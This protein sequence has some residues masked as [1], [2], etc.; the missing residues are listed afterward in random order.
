MK[1]ISLAL[2][3]LAGLLATCQASYNPQLQQ[4]LDPKLTLNSAKERPNIVFILTDDQ[5]LQ[6]DSLSYMPLTTKHLKK[7][8]T[9]YKNHFVP[10]AICCPARVSLWT[11]RFAHNTNVTDVSPPYGGYPKFVE[12]G[13]N[14]NFL[15]VW[16][17][18]AGYQTYYVGKLFNAHTVDNYNAPYVA[19]FNGSD[20]LLDPYTYS[21]L[22]ATYQRNHDPPV[23]Y[24]GRHTVDVTTEKA[25]GFLD[26][27]IATQQ[28]FFLGIAPV[29]PHSNVDPS[30]KTSEKSIIKMTEPIPA[31]RHKHLFQDVKVPRTEHFNPDTPSGVNWISRLPKQNRSN[32]D[33]NDHFY[34]SRLRALQ[35]VDELVDKVVTRLADAGILDNTYIIYTSDN[36]YHIGQHRLQP[37][38]ECGFEEDIRVPL[39]IRGPGVAADYTE[40]TVTTHIDLAP[41]VFQIAGI[42]QREDFDGVPVPLTRNSRATRHEHA[43]V[44]F[45]G[46]ALP[47][48][49]YNYLG[50]DNPPIITNNTYKG[51]RIHGSGYDLYYSVWC[52]GEHELYDLTIDPYE[53]DNIYP[54][55]DIDGD[56]KV[57]ILGY[58]RTQ[59]I[60]RLDALLLVLKSCQGITCVKPWE[61][62]HPEGDVQS[63]HDAL[64]KKFDDFYSQQVKVSYDRCESGY[65]VEAEGPQVPLT[66]RNGIAWHHW[67]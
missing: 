31:D 16:L 9:F 14:S 29:A 48:G 11:G 10:T 53:L 60:N 2:S 66:Y 21:Y 24:E 47:E 57:T 46:I 38:K 23:S 4:P 25:L 49:E 33:Y 20:F 56:D 43:N 5:D 52:S 1:A 40:E 35:G 19:G 26:D 36:G 15:P 34:R 8:G 13:F 58:P 54:T 51:L 12:R 37:G 67:V 64:N 30:F 6:L 3:A 7:G 62:L 44:E 41:T 18:S 22:N 55:S 65:I 45:W 50:P 39:F 32:V 17:Q 27:A 61:V 59:V 28:P 63:L 42:K